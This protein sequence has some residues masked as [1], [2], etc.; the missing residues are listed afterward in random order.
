M[1]YWVSQHKNR[2]TFRNL[3]TLRA[4]TKLNIAT[5]LTK[6]SVLKPLNSLAALILELLF[7]PCHNNLKNR[8]WYFCW[9]TRWSPGLF[10]ALRCPTQ[11][12]LFFH[13]FP[14]RRV[15]LCIMNRLRPKKFRSKI[16][17]IGHFFNILGY[18]GQKM[19]KSQEKDFRFR[20]RFETFWIGSD[21][22]N[23]TKIFWL[24]HF[25]TILAEKQQ[26]PR[27]KICKEKNLSISR[28][29]V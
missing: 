24:S 4:L 29:S 28:F 11:A 8:G 26:S 15:S 12:L 9:K 16:F 18:F 5:F 6:W 13:L 14:S 7:F 21:Q 25:F 1:C 27:K 17:W 19:T 22:K 10:Q 3:S 20:I 23:S 2:T